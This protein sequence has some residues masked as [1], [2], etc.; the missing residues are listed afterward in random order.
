LGPFR[1]RYNPARPAR[2]HHGRNVIALTAVSFLTGVK[3][4]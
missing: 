1:A 2:A 4:P 3:A